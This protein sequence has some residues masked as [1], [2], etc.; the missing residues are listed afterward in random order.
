M[1]AAKPRKVISQV[2]RARLYSLGCW[3]LLALAAHLLTQSS[4]LAAE[5]GAATDQE[6]RNRLKDANTPYLLL[7]ADNPVDWYP[8]GDEAFEKARKENKPIFLSVGYSTCFWCHVAERV[9]YSDP[10]IAELMNK[11]FVNVKVDREQR[12]DVDETY[13]LARQIIEGRGGWP[14]NVFMTPDGKAFYAGSYFPPEQDEQGRPGFP[15]ILRSINRTWIMRPEYLQGIANNVQRSMQA[16]SQQGVG[17][18][19]S[20]D[21]VPARLLAIARRGLLASF[22]DWHGGFSSTGSGI[23][24]P[25][26]PLLNLLL[27]DHR[28]NGDPKAL[29]ALTKTLTGMAYGGIYDHLGGGFHRYS[30]EPTWS[31]PHFEKMLYD[32]AQLLAIYAKAYEATGDPLFRHVTEDIAHYLTTQMMDP[33]GGFYTAEDAQ[34]AGIEGPNYRWKEEEIQQIL[35]PERAAAFLEAYELVPVPEVA[36]ETGAEEHDIGDVLRLRLPIEG[37]VTAGRILETPRYIE[38][39]RRAAQHLWDR[40]YDPATGLVMHQ[41]FRGRVQTNGFLADYAHFG[42]GAFALFQATEDDVWRDRAALLADQITRRF[43]GPNGALAMTEASESF[44]LAMESRGDNAYP[45]GTSAAIRLLLRLGGR[46]TASPQAEAA[47][48]ILEHY[49]Y[50]LD[51][52]PEKW[53]AAVVAVADWGPIATAEIASSEEKS[54]PPQPD[55]VA[56]VYALPETADHVRVAAGLKRDAAGLSV[57]V[58]LNIDEGYHVNAN[59]ASYEYLIPVTVQFDGLDPVRVVYPEASIFE[60]DFAEEGILVYEGAPDV[61]SAFSNESLKGVKEISAT[62]T[63][64]AC[65]DKVCLP[66]SDFPITLPVPELDSDGG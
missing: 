48:R 5:A 24:F 8:W 32:N 35:G 3:V 23:K 64:Q 49:S 45:S 6:Y 18:A 39:A 52:N 20:V 21:L 14:N 7:H 65:N 53:A 40:V 50:Q 42:N 66:P 4:S 28:V 61:V 31:V 13:M 29:D 46:D 34:I 47:R 12:P 9:L 60:P 30:T 26:S 63:A 62:V 36:A 16:A 44:L 55:Q 38:A 2:F 10:E 51:L 59:P 58:S 56:T 11:W 19:Q 15:Q 17:G 33:E 22:D 41:M 54:V 27:T 37:F 43:M 25:Q 57:T 1:R